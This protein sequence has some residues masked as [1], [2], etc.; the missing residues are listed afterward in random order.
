MR[1]PEFIKKLEDLSINPSILKE[2]EEFGMTEAESDIYM[3]LLVE[4]RATAGQLSKLSGYSRPKTY[5]A[6]EKLRKEGLIEVHYGRPKQYHAI[7][8]SVSLEKYVVSKASTLQKVYKEL[9]P[10]LSEIYAE[11][12]EEEVSEETVVWIVE[13]KRNFLIKM[14][15]LLKK[16]EKEARLMSG[17]FIE[18]EVDLLVQLA[19]HL[20][21]KDVK[22][23]M[24]APRKSMLPGQKMKEHLQLLA[25]KFEVNVILRGS[26]GEEW[27]IPPIKMLMIDL[28]AVIVCLP[29]IR[30]GKHPKIV[31]VTGLYIENQIMIDSIISLYNMF[32]GMAEKF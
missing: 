28:K 10:V 20:H 1:K 6:L 32:R 11:K 26:N 21:E 27:M 24:L 4:G 30:R 13:G 12:E 16:A 19:D 5:E 3:L 15:E 29:R 7:D 23:M 18:G 9:S 22:V 31:S 25:K 14:E 8:P 17:Y 2:L